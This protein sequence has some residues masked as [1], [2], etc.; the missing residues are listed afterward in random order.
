M[1][2]TGLDKGPKAGYEAEAQAFG[3]LAM[4]SHSKGL[5][6]LFRGQTECK[7][8]R[9]GAPEKPVKNLAVLGAGLMGAGIAQVSI[10]KGYNVVLKD[11]TRA[12][13]SRG[14]G[15]IQTGYAGGVKRKRFTK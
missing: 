6:G 1:V 9:F 12:G 14:V 13:L 3:Q 8:N 4:T 7:K 15:Q 11:A 2:R 10:D 5:M